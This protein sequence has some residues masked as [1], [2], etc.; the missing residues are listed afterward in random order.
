MGWKLTVIAAITSTLSRR[1]TALFP[2][3]TLT[4]S[5]SERSVLLTASLRQ[6][7]IL[8]TSTIVRTQTSGSTILQST[9]FDQIATAVCHTD[10]VASPRADHVLL[11]SS[12]FKADTVQRAAGVAEVAA[13]TTVTYV[14]TTYT[15]SS[16]FTT[17]A[18]TPTRTETSKSDP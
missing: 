13:T 8:L 17:I 2:G 15:S 12:N 10:T 16:T 3:P 5:C 6:S 14:E 1:V 4:T 9:I 18:P 7:T 11:D